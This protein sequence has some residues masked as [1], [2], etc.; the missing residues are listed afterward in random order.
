M[1]AK[2]QLV[3]L[4]LATAVY[5]SITC[6]CAQRKLF[7]FD[8]I[9]TYY[10]ARLPDNNAIR[11]ACEQLLNPPLF[12]IVTRWSQQLFG[13][14]ELGT[15]FPEIVGFWV[16]CLGVYLF[17]A[18]RASPIAA[19]ISLLYPLTTSGY[20]YA[21]EAR[22][23]GI[24]VGLFGLALISWQELTDDTSH[25]WTAAAGLAA[26]LAVAMLFHG[27]AFLLLIPLGLG[28][29]TRSLVRSRVDPLVWC[30]LTVPAILSVVTVLPLLHG[31]HSS[32]PRIFLTG[33]PVQ[34][35]WTAWELSFKPSFVLALLILLSV[36]AVSPR[37][38]L[39]IVNAGAAES[40]GRG[41]VLPEITALV[42]MFCTPLFAYFASRLGHAPFFSR[43]SLIVVGGGALLIG[44]A[45]ARYNATGI[46]VLAM[47]LLFIARSTA[48]F[49]AG[50]EVREPSSGMQVSTRLVAER[51]R[52]E[53][54]ES[55]APGTDPIV[56]LHALATVPTFHYAPSSLTSRCLFLIPDDT[57]DLY[58]RL[59][60]CCRAPGKVSSQSE[61][62]S[63]HHKFFVFGDPDTLFHQTDFY[64][65]LGGRVT[66][67]SC[68]EGDCIL[69]FDFSGGSITPVSLK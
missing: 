59:Q 39:R 61:F 67:Q 23:H 18:R 21:Y 5:F 57:V 13:A 17:V 30:A 19:F 2:Y 42:G 29:L 8:E 51:N 15:R 11:A 66:D 35:I 20:W 34:R 56:L 10:I 38:A 4:A 40:S 65:K 6:Y 47:T 48:T 63:A 16:F 49:H 37:L 46:L 9:F 24:L 7:W 3:F 55:A 54:I 25:R 43:Y 12:Y 28:E 45:A 53:W 52:F 62:L 41:L 22:P 32:V 27:Y 58:M 69:R 44:V 33:V 36:P 50:L 1:L 31:I 14:N 68:R 26:S 64:R 60:R